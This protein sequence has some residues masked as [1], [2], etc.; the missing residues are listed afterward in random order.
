M[1]PRNRDGKYAQEARGQVQRPNGFDYGAPAELF[2]MAGAGRRPKGNITYKRFGTAAEALRFAVEE[3][4]APA[5]AG[6]YL[7]VD[8]ARFGSREIQDLY[9]DAAYPL[10]R[11]VATD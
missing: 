5:L 2:V 10:T 11:L 4:N 8:E 7:E 9:E 3:M 1:A 6:A